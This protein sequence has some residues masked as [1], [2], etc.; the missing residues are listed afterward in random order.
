MPTVLVEVV[1]GLV[2][3]RKRCAWPQQAWHA[4]PHGAA[5][6]LEEVQRVSLKSDALALAKIM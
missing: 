1:V 5:A 2:G 4:T 6:H 3:E